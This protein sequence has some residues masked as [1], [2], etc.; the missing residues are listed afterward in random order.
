MLQGNPATYERVI[1]RLFASLVVYLAKV[2]PA[3]SVSKIIGV[4]GHEGG[5]ELPR[6]HWSQE[7]AVH[8][9]SYSFL[10]LVGGRSGSGA[11]LRVAPWGRFRRGRM[12]WSSVHGEKSS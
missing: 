12:K 2:D 4:D 11:V 6:G 9:F 7:V 3:R 10:A 5:H 1:H 8:V